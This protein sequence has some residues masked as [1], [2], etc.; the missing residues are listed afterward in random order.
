MSPVRIDDPLPPE[1]PLRLLVKGSRGW[2]I[3]LTI[4]ARDIHKTS[5]W[6]MLALELDPNVQWKFEQT[7]GK[8]VRERLWAW[9]RGLVA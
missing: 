5:D 2:N 6:A 4:K 8:L 1:T 7:T 9:F 3:V